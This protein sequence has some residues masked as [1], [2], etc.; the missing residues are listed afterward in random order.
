MRYQCDILGFEDNFIE[1][2]ERWTRQEV[3]TFDKL[4]GDAY[5]AMLQRKLTGICLSRLDGETGNPI[6]P[7]DTPKNFTREASWLVD[8]AA[9]RWFIH[10]IR[11]GF[12]EMVRLGEASAQ[13]WSSAQETK[14]VDTDKPA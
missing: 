13:S 11:L 14:A 4:E 12:N 2:S 3:F 5:F 9:W 8:F 6:D 10:A 7:I 1:L